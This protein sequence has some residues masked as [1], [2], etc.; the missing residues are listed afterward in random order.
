MKD[1]E[2][3][4]EYIEE[5]NVIVTGTYRYNFQ[6]SRSCGAVTVYEGNKVSEESFELYSELLECGL[7]EEGFKKKFDHVVHEIKSGKLDISF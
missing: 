3:M 1:Y 4:S 6:E 5:K 2:K 7:D